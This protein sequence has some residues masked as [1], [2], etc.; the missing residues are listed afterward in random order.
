MDW[1]DEK[2]DIL[3]KWLRNLSIW[4]AL[5]VYFF[6]CIVSVAAIF[7]ITIMICD[8]NT[9][10]IWS[11]Y[12]DVYHQFSSVVETDSYNLG[13]LSDSETLV[14]KILDFIRNWCLVIYSFFGIIGV[15]LLFYHNKLKQP[16]RLLK[17]S[18]SQVGRNNLDIEIFYDSKDEL[19]DLCRSFDSM[20]RE[21]IKNNQKM[22]DM[23]EEQKRLN[24]AFA[25][26]LRTP[27]TVLR[28]YTD[29]LKEYI[30]EGK[31]S[32]EK[33]I[34]TLTMMSGQLE[35]LE[36]YSN[37]MKDIHCVEDIPVK[38][39]Q[40]TNKNLIEKVENIRASLDGKNGVSIRLLNEIPDELRFL[41]I[42]EAIILEVL[43]NLL[44]NALR[45]AISEVRIMLA[46]SDNLHQ[47]MI[48]VTDDGKGFSNKDIVMATRPYYTDSSETKSGHYGIG[49]YICKLLC[50]KHGGWI[51]LANSMNQGAV[52]TTAFD[53]TPLKSY[54]NLD[55]CETI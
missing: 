10:D 53:I 4:K 44:S 19:G 5:M 37:T 42:D 23:M 15:S 48:S 24:A 7:A 20:R 40:V 35:R 34:K 29:L 39:T 3:W 27:L 38:K 9:D 21:L 30:P 16:L 14:I 31:I 6:I 26:D 17:E 32:E 47:V 45:Y 12:Y 52:V 49:L 1:L 28:G 22:W 43:E 18:A 13:L 51:A 55:N 46:V 54:I 36:N 41:Y 33:L 25:H 2:I 11:K 50:D 8:K